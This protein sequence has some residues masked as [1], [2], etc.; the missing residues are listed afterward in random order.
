MYLIKNLSIL[1]I[2]PVLEAIWDEV[3]KEFGPGVITSAHRPRDRGVHGTYP[4]TRGIDRRCRDKA[5]GRQIEAYV[6]AWWEYDGDR[7]RCCLFHRMGRCPKC[8]AF[9]EV[10]IEKGPTA[11]DKCRKCG[12]GHLKDMGPHLH[13]QSH[14]KTRR[15]TFKS[16]CGRWPA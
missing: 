16:T 9:T 6:N 10:D 15:K 12:A 13:F 3:E 7:K 2:D 4:K 1:N 8:G 5:L 11:K 14:P